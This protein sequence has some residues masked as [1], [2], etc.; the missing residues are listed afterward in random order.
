MFLLILITCISFILAFAHI[1][2][3][4]VVNCIN[5]DTREEVQLKATIAGHRRELRGISMKDDYTTY[6]KIERKIVAAE[7]RLSDLAILNSTSKLV[8]RYGI[9]YGTQAVLSL[10]LIGISIYFRSTPVLVFDEKFDLVPF[11]AI[12]RIPTGVPG[13]ISVPFW[14]FVS[15]FMGRTLAGYAKTT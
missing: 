7:K 11:G 4:P 5:T 14:I 9:P 13:A 3:K 6:V 8:I 2:T 15:S 12:M 10:V 1:L